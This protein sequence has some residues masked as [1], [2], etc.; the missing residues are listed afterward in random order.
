[1]IH[2]IPLIRIPYWELDTLTFERI[3]TCSRLSSNKQI[4]QRLFNSKEVLKYG[5][6]SNFGFIKL[7]GAAVGGI[8]SIISLGAL[9]MK[10]PKN[11]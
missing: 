8:F 6:D 4:S 2:N 9:I 3:F 11:G 5:M 10:K 1:M 7:V